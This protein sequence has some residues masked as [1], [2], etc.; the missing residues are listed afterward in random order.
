MIRVGGLS[1]HGYG[2]PHTVNQE[3]FIIGLITQTT[4]A[5]F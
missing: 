4:E 3:L 1:S 5:L 2:T